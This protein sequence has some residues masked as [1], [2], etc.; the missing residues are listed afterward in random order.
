MKNLASILC[1]SIA[2]AAAAGAQEPLNQNIPDPPQR[3][4]STGAARDG[5]FVRDGKVFIV[6]NG[7]TTQVE[8]EMLF[9]NGLRVQP[10]ATVTLRDGREV[11]LLPKQWLTFEGSIDDRVV[12][13]SPKRPLAVRE[14]VV[15]ESGVS[16]R[17]GV[18]IS[19]A[20][21]FITRNGRTEKVA[22]DLHMPNGAIVHADGTVL[23]ANGRKVTLRADQVLD[24]HGVLHEAPVVPNPPG[25]DPALSNP[26]R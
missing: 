14:S 21:V 9:P 1:I 8:R 10:N 4:I 16:A 24:L 26:S 15:R 20:D 3:S 6:R 2:L 23:L 19:G 22:G 7:L 11:T 18:T 25:I 13:V 17:D 5:F 12:E